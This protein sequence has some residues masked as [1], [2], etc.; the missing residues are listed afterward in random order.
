MKNSILC[1]CIILTAI[2]LMDVVERKYGE[3]RESQTASEA[4]KVAPIRVVYSNRGSTIWQLNNTAKQEACVRRIG[5]LASQI[6]PTPSADLITY[7]YQLCLRQNGVS[8]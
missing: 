1:L 8:I 7:N 4:R 5:E 3:F 2:P 6:S